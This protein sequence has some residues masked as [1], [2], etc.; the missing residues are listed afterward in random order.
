MMIN[1][2]SILHL[3]EF[4]QYY[5]LFR[6]LCLSSAYTQRCHTHTASHFTL[7]CRKEEDSAKKI[8]YKNEIIDT[9]YTAV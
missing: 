3:V 5:R 6:L 9:Q 7:M 8:Q 2:P 4:C 1:K